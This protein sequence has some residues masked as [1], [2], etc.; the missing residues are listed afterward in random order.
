MIT[1]AKIAPL[2]NQQIDL[3]Y[4]EQLKAKLAQ[5]RRERQPL[6][7]TATEFEEILRWKLGQQIGRQRE[8]RAANTDEVIRAVTGLALIITHDD[9][10]YEL[11][12]RVNILCTLRGVAIPVASAVLALVFPEEYAVIDYR[13]WRQVFGEG[14]GNYSL[15]GYK[16]Y[17]G[18]IRRL[19]KEL[20]W[21]VQE[22]D[23]VIWEYDR[24]RSEQMRSK[25]RTQ[26]PKR[27]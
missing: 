10:E 6:Y 22:V 12:L 27:A 15:P 4:T 3:A 11:E 13:G 17:M 16:K 21:P 26:K 18:E 9:K 23:H 20:G 8:I 24:R 2:R 25:A 14:Q 19:A 7:L 5:L 1:A